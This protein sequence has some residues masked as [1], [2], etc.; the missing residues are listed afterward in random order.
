[1]RTGTQNLL[2]RT[3]CTNNTRAKNYI[4]QLKQIYKLSD[5]QV[6]MDLTQP[7]SVWVCL[8][9]GGEHFPTRADRLW[10]LLGRKRQP[11]RQFGRA[12]GHTAT[13]QTRGG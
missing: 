4:A 12:Q 1:M 6:R 7:M 10:P 11:R 5:T 3:S 13:Y 8:A 9:A 2:S